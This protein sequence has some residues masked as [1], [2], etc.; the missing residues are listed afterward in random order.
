MTVVSDRIKGLIEASGLSIR[1]LAR[2][3]DVSNV[4]LSQ[5]ASGKYKPSD[6]GLEALC[7][8]FSVPPAYILYGDGNAPGAQTLQLSNDTVA[9]PLLDVSASCG[10]GEDFAN[11]VFALIRFVRV[12]YEFIRR[13]C[14]SANVRS[15]QLVTVSG[16][17]MVPTLSDGDAVLV[18]V[19][20]KEPT[21]DGIYAVLMNNRIFVKRLQNLP[22]GINLISDNPVYPPICIREPDTLHI[23]GRCYVGLAIKAL[24]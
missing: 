8:Y 12:S 22:D 13:Y 23:V 9:V 17:S 20:Q 19:S 4:S 3:I 1:E 2:R 11:S 24:V 5:W 18:D 7:S 14:S 6:E 16:D 15:L 10:F 21:S